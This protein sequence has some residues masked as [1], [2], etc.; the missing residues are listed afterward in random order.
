MENGS[1][2]NGKY[3]YHVELADESDF[4]GYDTY[5]EF[6]ACADSE[7]EVRKM[8]PDGV[9]NENDEGINWDCKRLNNR[10]GGGWVDFDDRESLKVTMLGEAKDVV[11]G[12]IVASFHAG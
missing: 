8:H 3:L 10:Y 4:G 7:E 9:L 5:S 1:G 12:V 2:K 11:K 6:V